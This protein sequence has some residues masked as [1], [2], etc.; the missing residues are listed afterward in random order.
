MK[1]KKIGLSRS[2]WKLTS[3]IVRGG[4]LT[5]AGLAAGRW[6]MASSRQMPSPV[7]GADDGGTDG[8]GRKEAKRAKASA[9]TAAAH[10]HVVRRLSHQGGGSGLPLDGA[11]E[12]VRRLGR[13]AQSST[14]GTT[15][16]VDGDSG[17]RSWCS[18]SS[19]QRAGSID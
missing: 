11:A 7:W 14:E 19:W 5:T 13:G 8:S 17:V 4:D 12:S 15:V 16:V 18:G 3:G 6:T 9:S 10:R 1:N 2:R